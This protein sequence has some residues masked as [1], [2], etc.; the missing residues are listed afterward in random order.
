MIEIECLACG[1]TVKLPQFIN[2]DKYDGQVVCQECESLLQVKLVKGKVEKYKVIVNNSSRYL[3]WAELV[4]KFDEAKRRQEKA[5]GD[6]P[7]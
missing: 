4:K 6:S 5:G 2:T 7:Q 1:K 3:S